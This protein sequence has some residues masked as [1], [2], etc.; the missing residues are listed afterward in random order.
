MMT[1]KKTQISTELELEAIVRLN[2]S[3]APAT[4]HLSSAGIVELTVLKTCQEVSIYF[5]GR[6]KFGPDRISRFE[7]IR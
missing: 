4:A 2:A 1:Q 6:A 5:L 3:Y 7:T